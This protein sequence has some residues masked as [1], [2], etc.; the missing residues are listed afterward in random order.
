MGPGWERLCSQQGQ[1]EPGRLVATEK[2]WSVCIFL[3][4]HLPQG[5]CV[6]DQVVS[7]NLLEP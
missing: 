3:D 7:N 5:L 2:C 4:K 6:P 1:E